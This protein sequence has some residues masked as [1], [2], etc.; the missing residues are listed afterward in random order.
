MVK[1]VSNS[2]APF[3]RQQRRF[4]WSLKDVE[5]PFL[6]YSIQVQQ[7]AHSVGGNRKGN[8]REAHC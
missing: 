5:K 4:L 6:N 8:V 7:D 2:R 3:L 1:N